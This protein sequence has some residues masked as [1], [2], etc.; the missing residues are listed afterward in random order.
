MS[1]RLVIK[2]NQ[3][4]YRW[5]QRPLVVVCVGGCEYD[6]L[7]LAIAS[8]DAPFLVRMIASG[9]AFKTRL[10]NFDIFDVTLNHLE[11]A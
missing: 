2:V 4:S 6:Y 9:T 3:R 7:S 11:T 1:A 8:G 10:R 5:M